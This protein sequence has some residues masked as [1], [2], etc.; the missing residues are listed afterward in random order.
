MN[1]DHL[2][3]SELFVLL[4]CIFLLIA[5]QT[6]KIYAEYTENLSLIDE[7]EKKYA[8]ILA[9]I[10]IDEEEQIDTPPLITLSEEDEN[11]K[12]ASGSDHISIRY[13]KKLYED[14]VP[15]LEELSLKY[16]CNA[17]QI[18]GHT[19]G[20][21]LSQRHFP[22]SNLDKHL[23]EKLHTETS[24]MPGSNV[25]L[26][27][28][29]AVAVMKVLQKNRHDGHLSAIEYWFPYSAGPIINTDGKII[30]KLHIKNDQLQDDPERRRVEIRLFRFEENNR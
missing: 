5:T 15:H 6:S 26:G 22:R 14:I 29:R 20:Q 13:E 24:L 8:E 21:A 30:K 12:F 17:I 27:M 7:Y 4:A 2:K 25:D 9:L 10:D 1:H 28:M 16:D 11:Y 3:Q 19:S 18:I 23:I